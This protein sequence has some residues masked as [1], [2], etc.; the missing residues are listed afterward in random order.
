MGGVSHGKDRAGDLGAEGMAQDG[1]GG[2]VAEV[3]P[4][5]EGKGDH[6]ARK[7]PTALGVTDHLSLSEP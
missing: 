4:G 3:K 1:A 2:T 6:G 7:G 5:S